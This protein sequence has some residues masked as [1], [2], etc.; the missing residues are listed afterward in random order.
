VLTITD[1]VDRMAAA[2]SSGAGAATGIDITSNSAASYRISFFLHVTGLSGNDIGFGNI[3]LDFG[4]TNLRR[5]A[6]PAR[7]AYQAENAAVVIDADGDVASQWG[8]N[9]DVGTPNDLKAILISLAGGLAPDDPRIGGNFGLQPAS[10][11]DQTT[12]YI[13]SVWVTFP[14]NT[15]ANTGLFHLG[16]TPGSAQWSTV[17]VNASGNTVFITRNDAIGYPV[18]LPPDIL[19]GTAVTA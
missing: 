9:A 7:N 17:Q 11:P 13:G 8:L 16:L 12:G 10:T 18:V 1:V 4:L 5:D 14:G 3:A 15:S 6:A 2:D 19:F